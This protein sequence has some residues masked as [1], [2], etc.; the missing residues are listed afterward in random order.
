MNDL[1]FAFRQLL[2]HPGFTAVAVLTLAL[3]IGFVTTL[4]TMINGVAYGRLPF[5]DPDRI[6][7]IGVPATRFDDFAREQKSCETLAFALPTPQNIRAGAFV[8]RYPS[9]IV[10]ANFL[11]VLRTKPAFG[12]GFQ[13]EDTRPGAA[14]TVLI[15]HTVWERE[16]ERAPDVVGR[17]LRLDG[18][19]ATVVGVMPPGFGFPF[20]QEVW[21]PR[22]TDEPVQGGFVFGRLRQDVGPAKAAE[23]FATIGRRLQEAAGP[24]AASAADG[25]V[26]DADA[27]VDP[28]GKVRSVEVVPFAQRSVKDA[29][30]VMLTS[31]LAATFL[32]LLLACAN[33]ANL[34][35]ARSVDRRKEMAIR[36]ALGAS[37]ARLVRQ[38]LWESTLVAVLGAGGG[39]L[40]AAASTRALWHYL[41]TERPLTGGAPF[42]MNFDLDGRV[43]LFVA[44]VA[45][46]AG[47]LTGL[48]P[49]L[50]A[51]S[52]APNDAL[53][54]TGGGS[55]R[56]SRFS[57]VLVNAQM[58][59]S[60]C[61]V[62]VAGLF[63]A[64][65]VAF[66]HK[67]LPYDPAS[68]LTARIALDAPRYNDANTRLR[69]FETLLAQV[70]NSPG[71][72]SA[73][74]V[75]AEALRSREM[76]KI[77]LEG[78]VYARPNDRPDC[79]IESV[80]PGFL[81]AFGVGPV[82]GRALNDADTAS[83]APVA[84]V[85]SAFAARFG[86]EAEVIGRRVR[87]G[88][89]GTNTLPWFT[90]VGIVPELGSVKAGQASAGAV[91]YRPLAQRPY[92][93][94][95]LVVR[96]QGDPARFTTAI[97]EAVATLDPEL[98]VAQIQTVQAILEM[99]RV[100]MN[101]FGVLFVVCGA[102]ALVLASVGLYGI[103]SLGVKLRTRE[104]GVR[105]AIGANRGD[106]RRLVLGQGVKLIGFGLA[107]GLLLAVAAS[108]ALRS[109][110]PH[111]APSLSDLWIGVAVVGVLVSAGAIALLIPARR[112]ANADPMIA[113]RSE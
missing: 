112:A 32:V 98:P 20:N 61:L 71:V 108:F 99:E 65:L 17:E 83:S 51:S 56:V 18:A 55:R 95:T 43:F 78:A 91:I 54:D 106:L 21:I 8:S 84:V 44:A 52:V 100:G 2:K 13:P 26:W 105:L 29:L 68:V 88:A 59:F 45:L 49:A 24:N 63:A 104:F 30:H 12:R 38:L 111:F 67:T 97:R 60:V 47:L 77:E 69:F 75:S 16:F 92:R 58:A 46:L 41:M 107:I 80:S 15:G 19:V 64:V 57:Q 66:N 40:V 72:A 73:A 87:F 94:M 82:A 10:S 90:I 5:E 3:G 6:V 36:V 34:I 79:L 109:L 113:L 4:F 39:L 14:R 110:I 81:D 76:P 70:K 48:A 101:A 53:K 23:E 7:S 93:A 33:V 1:K 50:K 89:N 96:G 62:T 31:I 103:I 22:R 86:R 102:G 28:D 11:E 25:F 42:W 9:A 35:L 85:N 27:K 37:R 74:W